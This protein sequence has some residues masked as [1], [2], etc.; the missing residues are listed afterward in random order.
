MISGFLYA[1]LFQHRDDINFSTVLY[2]GVQK[3]VV[4][5][6]NP[7]PSFLSFRFSSTCPILRRASRNLYKT[8]ALLSRFRMVIIT[9]KSHKNSSQ[10]MKMFGSKV[11]ISI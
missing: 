7:D 3:S 1:S 4:G 11:T 9:Y 10:N 2:R 8:E 5:Q 6:E